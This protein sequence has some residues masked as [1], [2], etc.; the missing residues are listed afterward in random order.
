MTKFLDE[1]LIDNSQVI[2]KF[3]FVTKPNPNYLDT[4]S[5]TVEPAS[6]VQ[7]GGD[8]YKHKPMQPEDFSYVNK[9]GWHEG[10][11]VKY[12]TR[13][14]DKNGLEDLQ[15]ARHVI[16]LLIEKVEKYADN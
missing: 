16:E 4:Y 1:P 7:I 13:W 14:K 10:E 8:H 5:D 11:I 9:L 6:K 12:V 3:M 2:E 15:K